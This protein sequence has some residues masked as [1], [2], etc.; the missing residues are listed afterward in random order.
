M[1]RAYTPAGWITF[2]LHEDLNEASMIALEG[3]LDLMEELYGF[4]RKEAY[5]LASLTV[6]MRITQM[7]NGVKGVHA[8]LPHDVLLTPKLS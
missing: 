1:P 5:T 8:I 3:M 7:V 2:G 4:K 6:D